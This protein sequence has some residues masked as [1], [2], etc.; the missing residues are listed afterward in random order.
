MGLDILKF[1]IN[2]NHVIFRIYI[3]FL[4]NKIR[5][6]VPIIQQKIECV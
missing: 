3:Y 4:K 1:E 2:Q 6:Y 5:I